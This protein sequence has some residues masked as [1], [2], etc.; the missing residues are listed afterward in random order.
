MKEYPTY[1][2]YSFI[3]RWSQDGI[4]N[5]EN[6]K[7]YE[8]L[9]EGRIW[10]STSFSKMYKEEQSQEVLNQFVS[11]WWEKYSKKPNYPI[12]N[13][14]DVILTAEYKEHESWVITW[15]QHE[16]FDVGQSDEEALDS[17]EQFVRRYENMQSLS[18]DMYPENYHSLMGAEDRW[19]WY[20]TIDGT[21]DSESPAPCRCKFCKEAGLIKIGH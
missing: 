6:P 17:F 2:I 5:P 13:P 7:G 21:P 8:G 10:N 9:P 4:Q 11:E 3:A 20:G 19:R 16:T 1:P 18:Y 12:V 14:S 15:F